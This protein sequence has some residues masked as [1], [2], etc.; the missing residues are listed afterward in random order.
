ELVTQALIDFVSRLLTPPARL[1]L[2]AVFTH[3]LSL[4]TEQR[5]QFRETVRIV[6]ADLVQLGL[7]S[8]GSESF[9]LDE[10]TAG[11]L[12][13]GQPHAGDVLLAADLGGGT[14]DVSLGRGTGTQRDQIGS[15]ECGGHFFLSALCQRN[16]SDVRQVQR[17][18]RSRPDEVRARLS[19]PGTS[20]LLE[21]YTGQL[22]FFLETMIA[23]YVLRR[24]APLEVVVDPLEVK[25][26]LLGNGWG[27]FRFLA[28]AGD[29]PDH[30]WEES[31][32][33]LLRRMEQDLRLALDHDLRLTWARGERPPKHAVAHGALKLAQAG[34]GAARPAAA[35]SLPTGVGCSVG[36]T[37]GFHLDWH[38][39]FGPATD[40]NP[41]LRDR[42]I[43]DTVAFDFDE[44]DRRLAHAQALA[45]GAPVTREADGVVRQRLLAAQNRCGGVVPTGYLRGPL[46]LLLEHWTLKLGSP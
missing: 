19:K 16:E 3:P 39:L 34:G 20:R 41:N 10:S 25:L 28:H 6:H 15:L 44:L 22:L 14:L 11:I 38:E 8:A 32:A 45:P 23:S 46:Q 30:V 37:Q 43:D 5:G 18:I 42:A 27:F 36:G 4:T 17:S 12:S 1:D 29:D 40:H 26:Y 31:I 24:S 21:R 2:T 7:I 35:M 33:G 9:L 13:V